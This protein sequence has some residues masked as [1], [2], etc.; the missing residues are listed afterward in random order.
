MARVR[1]K[2]IADVVGVSTMT[3]SNAYNAPHRLSAE[4]RE[5]ILA[6]ASTM[7]YHGPGGA[8]RTLRSGK[9]NAYA[10]LF[11]EPLSYAFL[12]PYTVLLLA[13]FSEAME[14]RKAS[15]TLV[16][17]PPNDAEALNV[18]RSV[19]VDGLAGLC[20]SHPA[21]QVARERGLRTVA[22]DPVP[23]GDYVTIDDF[24]A[25]KAV[26]RHIRRLGHRRVTILAEVLDGDQPTPADFSVDEFG[27]VLDRYAA[28]G[29][30][31][32][33]LRLRGLFEGLGDAEVRV[34]V[35]GRN[36]RESGRLAG[37]FAL[38][39][40]DRPTAIIAGSDVMA[41]GVLDVMADRG[42][43]AGRDVSVAGF[44]DIPDAA[45]AGLTTLRQPIVEKGRL[46]AQLLLDPELAPRRVTLPCEL[47]VRSSTGPVPH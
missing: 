31:D 28:L 27:P 6:T 37:R 15:I 47:I 32:W 43:I 17:V 20:A 25:G 40:E 13:G 10:V 8:G 18:V 12:D 39:R 3:V 45:R 44:D 4:L 16:S 19:S 41:L 36:T 9:S 42:L 7:G 38:D 33:W 35:A 14:A 5:R 2:D 34:L 22:I 11:A 29:F 21:M 24:E 26:G 46:A 30:S 1:L 23:D